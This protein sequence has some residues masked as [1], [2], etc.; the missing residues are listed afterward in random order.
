[1]QQFDPNYDIVTPIRTQQGKVDVTVRFPN[2]SEWAEWFRTRRMQVTQLGRGA[3]TFQMDS[4]AADFKL[5]EQIRR[6]ESP[7]LDPA[8][9]SVLIE[10][11]GRREVSNIENEGDELDVT[12]AVFGGVATHRVRIPNAKQVGSFRRGSSQI[13][14][15]PF[16]KQQVKTALEPGIRL[17][18][19][20]LIGAKGY[21]NGTIPGIHKDEVMRSVLQFI[22][23]EADE[24]NP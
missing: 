18:D 8:E 4:E 19:E 2:D 5:Y 6:P 14:S 16:N 7:N 3:S 11:I 17:Y 1:M 12:L 22:E 21:S 9:A 15:L 24:A 20:C 23:Q 10:K 13:V